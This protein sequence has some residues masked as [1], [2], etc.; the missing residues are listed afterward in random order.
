MT[1]FLVPKI[2]CAIIQSPK[3]VY[4]NRAKWL[5][6]SVTWTIFAYE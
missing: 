6:V 1:I 2:D 3:K 5:Q 4:A